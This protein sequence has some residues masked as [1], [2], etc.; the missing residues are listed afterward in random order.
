MA[1]DA[2]KAETAAVRTLRDAVSGYAERMREAMASARRDADTLVKRAEEAA[3]RRKADL[4]RAL[5]TLKQTESELARC[6]DERQAIA[7]REKIVGLRRLTAERGQLHGYAV[8]AVKT[9]SGVRT[10]LLKTIQALDPVVSQNSSVAA[11]AL[12]SLEDHLAAIDLRDSGSAST[13]VV[14]GVRDALVT[15]A[16][17]AESVIGLGH[18][19]QFAQTIKHGYLSVDGHPATSSEIQAEQHAAS[20]EYLA[21]SDLMDRERHTGREELA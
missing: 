8:Q 5:G 15:G 9:A 20:V 1:D 12:A 7:L 2:I 11:H 14:R 3:A 18:A 19:G 4:E 10:D 21:T 6:P 16:F 17:A 13:R